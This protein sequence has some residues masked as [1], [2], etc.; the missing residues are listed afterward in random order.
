MG[1]KWNSYKPI[2]RSKLN[3]VKPKKLG[4]KPVLTQHKIS[5]LNFARLAISTMKISTLYRGPDES[6]IVAV[7]QL[8]EKFG[9][10]SVMV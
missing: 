1:K 2:K 3:K 7:V 5:R 9:D 10:G 4:R 6:Y 8:V